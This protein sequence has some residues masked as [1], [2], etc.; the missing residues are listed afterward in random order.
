[1]FGRGLKKQGCSEVVRV[2]FR[3]QNEHLTRGVV[4]TLEGTLYRDYNKYIVLIIVKYL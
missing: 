2:G 1:M 4:T 3:G